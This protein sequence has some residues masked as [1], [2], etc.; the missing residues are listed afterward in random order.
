VTSSLAVVEAAIRVK[1]VLLIKSFLKIRKK[2][3]M[4]INIFFT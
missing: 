1:S 4:E 3:N 2:E